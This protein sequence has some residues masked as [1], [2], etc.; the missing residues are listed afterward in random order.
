VN[1]PATLVRVLRSGLE[2][3]VH[4]GHVAVCDP[5]GRLVG[6]AGEPEQPVYARSCM[7]PIQAAV[8]LSVMESEAGQ[9][10]DREVAVMCASHNG[11]DVHIA[12]VLG[13][14]GRAGLDGRALRNPPGWPLDP[15]AMASAG[16]RRPELHNCSGKHAGMI[17]ATVRAGW[18]PGLYLKATEPLQQR[19]LQAVLRGTDAP[20][21]R[22]GTD[23]C[24][25]PVHGMALSR[26]ATLFA[27]LAE[28][29]RWDAL[30]ASVRRVTGAMV[31]EP[32]L[33]A[34]RNRTD[35]AVMEVAPNLVVKSG[36][37]GLICATA[38]DGRVGAAIKVAD[39]TGRAAGP[40]LIQVLAQLGLLDEAQVDRLRP[41]ARPDVLGGGRAVG[42]MIAS[43]DLVTG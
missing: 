8:S 28:P 37:E 40:A 1:E 9:L 36:A 35:T 26:M 23:G 25:L 6:H 12:T 43:F 38:M 19:V 27:R 30:G 7:K 33:V 15:E 18:D 22:V 3:S 29:D 20:E 13:I 5:G 2:E 31:A 41:Y 42:E 32:Y 4:L 11:E 16:S 21:V 34:G 14:L 24:G 17:L 10:S 39:G